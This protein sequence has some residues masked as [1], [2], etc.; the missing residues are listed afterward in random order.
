MLKAS[1]PRN[2]AL[3]PKRVVK[4]NIVH[5]KGRD[6]YTKIGLLIPL[7]PKPHLQRLYMLY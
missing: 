3:K 7:Y 2:L 1:L 6:R 4:T 5:R